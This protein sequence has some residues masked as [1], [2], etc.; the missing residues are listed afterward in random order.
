M[1][2]DQ[3]AALFRPKPPSSVRRAVDKWKKTS[4]LRPL[5]GKD[6]TVWVSGRAIRVDKWEVKEG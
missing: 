4:P 3:L 5:E 1:T 6:G 2:R